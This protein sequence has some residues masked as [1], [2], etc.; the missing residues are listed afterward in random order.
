MAFGA[1]LDR[2]A[3]GW[4]WRG[5]PARSNSNRRSWRISTAGS[6]L[7]PGSSALATTLIGFGA[8]RLTRGPH[9]VTASRRTGR[10]P[11]ISTSPQGCEIRARWSPFCPPDLRAADAHMRGLERRVTAGL[12][13][14]VRSV[15]SVFVSRRDK[16]T[17]PR[18][19]GTGS[20]LRSLSRPTKRIVTC[21]IRIVGNGLRAGAHARQRLLF[22]STSTKDKQV[23][24]VLYVTALAAPNTSIPCR[25][26]AAR[27][28]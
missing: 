16:A 19:S 11:T 20:V 7:S 3:T 26:D 5:K 10:S 14:D 13:P 25:G 1:S 17:L 8:A 9:S 27:V 4:M 15:A 12:D 22:A 21:W 18:N 6:T 2:Y 24:D 28:Q 23:S